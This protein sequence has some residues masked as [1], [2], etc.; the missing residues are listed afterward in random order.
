MPL[1]VLISG[2]PASGKTRLATVL[3]QATNLPVLSKDKIKERLFDTLGIE[4]S[5]DWS[6]RLGHA[7]FDLL[8]GLADDFA[9]SGVPCILENAF[10]RDDGPIL[11]QALGDASV[12]R[13]HCQATPA[14]LAR[15][16]QARIQDGTRQAAHHD[17]DLAEIIRACCVAPELDGP[18]IVVPTEDFSSEPY[19]DAV[20]RA[21]RDAKELRSA[22]ASR[23]GI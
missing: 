7:S 6:R 15:R 3:A 9:R 10:R 5:D 4:Y 19:R 14:T 23:R 21:V 16:I 11:Q 12:L 8:L 18:L 2:A 20:T 22:T 17:R 1:V 13:I